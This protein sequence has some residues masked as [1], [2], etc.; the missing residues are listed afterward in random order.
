MAKLGEQLMLHLAF[1]KSSFNKRGFE[2]TSIPHRVVKSHTRCPVLFSCRPGEVCV[3]QGYQFQ[4]EP[5]SEDERPR[6]L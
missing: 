3:P 4:V 2:L 6:G 1:G 5:G